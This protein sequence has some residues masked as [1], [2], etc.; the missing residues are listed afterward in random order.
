MPQPPFSGRAS[1]RFFRGAVWASASRVRRI[2]GW[3]NSESGVGFV[4]Q[5]L[6]AS[7]EGPPGDTRPKAVVHRPGFEDHIGCSDRFGKLSTL[8][9]SSTA[10][11]N[12]V[13]IRSDRR[14]TTMNIELS[15][16]YHSRGITI[17]QE[18]CLSRCRNPRCRVSPG[19]R[20]GLY[21]HAS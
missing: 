1:G 12:Y 21:T 7:S 17:R 5:R 16:F 11:Q 10:Y 4:T 9:D 20:A 15:R 19:V 13:L 3:M 18:T 14:C 2:A 6:W 8:H